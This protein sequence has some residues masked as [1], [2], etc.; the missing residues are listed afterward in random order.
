MSSEPYIRTLP[1][2]NDTVA[3][4]FFGV[5]GDGCFM[6]DIVLLIDWLYCIDLFSCI[7]ASLFNKLTYLLTYAACYESVNTCIQPSTVDTCDAR[8]LLVKVCL[9]DAAHTH[10]ATVFIPA[11]KLGVLSEAS[12]RLFYGPCLETVHFRAKV[13][14]VNLKPKYQTPCW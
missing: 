1:N 10:F 4:S 11:T 5:D 12:L 13:A 9:L 3:R 6:S 2:L 8:I 14:I 7:A